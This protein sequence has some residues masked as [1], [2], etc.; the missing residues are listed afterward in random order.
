MS[1]PAP[2]AREDEL[3]VVVESVR[4]VPSPCAPSSRFAFG[5]PLRKLFYF[6]WREGLRLTWSKVRAVRLQRR[7]EGEAVLVIV[8]GRTAD[9]QRCLCLGRQATPSLS[10][11][12]F[13]AHFCVALRDGAVDGVAI[14]E[15]VKTVSSSVDLFTQAMDYSVHS[16]TP[17]PSSVIVMLGSW[18]IP[19]TSPG[20]RGA[21]A[22]A[23]R[24]GGARDSRRYSLTLLGCGAYP[25]AYTLPA[26]RGAHRHCVVD[27]NP[28]IAAE[29]ARRYGF[30]M[31]DTDCNRALGDL[32]R[33]RT[34]LVVIATYHSSHAELVRRTFEVDPNARVFVE[35]PPVVDV[36]DVYDL[37]ERLNRGSFLEIGYNRRYAPMIERARSVLG[38]QEG[39][40]TMT[41][42]VKEL[43]LPANHWYFW[44]TQGTRVTGNLS[45]WFDL[46]TCFI[47]SDPVDIV[48]TRRTT[49]HGE[50]LCAT[51][52]YEDSSM[53]V[54]VATERG[55]GRKGVQETI[56]LRRANVTLLIDDFVR[57]VVTDEKTTRV[58]RSRIR[59]K[60]HMR[61]Y[62]ALEGAVIS[63]ASP[64]YPTRDLIR[65][66]LTY[67]SVARMVSDGEHYRKIDGFAPRA[68]AR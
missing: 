23:K 11:M 42:I 20:N 19:I 33:R 22:P 2:V 5:N 57:L 60:G 55:S 45:H 53:L 3:C 41:C 56:E 31:A 48:A 50:E 61:M 8:A 40:I 68:C 38:T 15:I 16:G 30:A 52:S 49:E 35:K 54:I 26:L 6:I 7:L 28:C 46:A 27:L 39:P 21:P 13:P 34:N 62:K 51:V 29:A 44:P 65:S 66:T 67:T 63:G 17:A 64:R 59:D 25:M 36:A 12:K 37:A 58:I 43:S 47:A 4:V 32:D 18:G 24:I 9:G 1:L 10:I 14:A